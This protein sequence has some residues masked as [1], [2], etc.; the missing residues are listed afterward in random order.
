MGWVWNVYR[1][2]PLNNCMRLQI[3]WFASVRTE[4]VKHKPILELNVGCDAEANA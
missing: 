1:R 3:E 4:Q 2:G